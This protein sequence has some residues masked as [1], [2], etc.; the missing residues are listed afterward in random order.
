M[1]TYNHMCHLISLGKVLHPISAFCSACYQ[2]HV[3]HINEGTMFMITGTG[4][5]GWCYC[6]ARFTVPNH[7]HTLIHSKSKSKSNSNFKLKLKMES[8]IW[9]LNSNS[10]FIFKSKIQNWTF[11]VHDST[12]NLVHQLRTPLTLS[13]PLPPPHQLIITI[14]TLVVKELCSL[15]GQCTVGSAHYLNL[16]ILKRPREGGATRCQRLQWGEKINAPKDVGAWTCLW[17]ILL[18]SWYAFF[19]RPNMADYVY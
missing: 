3:F 14:F 12:K 8:D 6:L 5:R 4:K 18:H 13:L 7:E 19:A 11:L 9:N 16:A 2:R 1:L 15:V 10:K 17:I